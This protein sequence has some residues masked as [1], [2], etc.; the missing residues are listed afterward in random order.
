MDKPISVLIDEYKKN[1]TDLLNNS[2]L[3]FWL[4]LM[5]TEPFLTQMR[6]V[7]DMQAKEEKEAYEA[8][9]KENNEETKGEENNE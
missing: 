5:I 2:Q 4:L 9:L 8:S 6:Q 3:P 7:A 1:F